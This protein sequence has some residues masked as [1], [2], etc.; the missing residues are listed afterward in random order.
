[1]FVVVGREFDLGLLLFKGS[2][3]G[4]PGQTIGNLPYIYERKLEKRRRGC[5]A[6][7]LLVEASRGDALSCCLALPKQFQII[8]WIWISSHC[9]MRRRTPQ[10]NNNHAY[11]NNLKTSRRSQALPKSA[12]KATDTEARAVEQG[13]VTGSR[14]HDGIPSELRCERSP[15]ISQADSCQPC[16]THP[17]EHARH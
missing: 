14:L 7:A 15:E 1:M 9:S 5:K 6:Q 17:T 8:A 4:T 3:K 11:H 12:A 2:E 13:P 10:L 16:R